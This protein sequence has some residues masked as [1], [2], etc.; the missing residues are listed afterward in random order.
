M[1]LLCFMFFV[2]FKTKKHYKK[3]K[4]IVFGFFTHFFLFFTTTKN[5]DLNKKKQKKVDP[6]R[7]QVAE[8]NVFRYNVVHISYQNHGGGSQLLVKHEACCN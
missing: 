4:S 6:L 1:I 7:Y 2:F 8:R 3:K 5:L